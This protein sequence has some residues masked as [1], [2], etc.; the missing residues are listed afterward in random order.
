MDISGERAF[1]LLQKIGYIRTSGT[2]E[3]MKTAEILKAEAESCGVAAVIEP[4]DVEDAEITAASLTVLAPYEKTYEVTAYKCA[5]NTP[6][7]GLVADFYY[8]ENLSDAD[9]AA[10]KGKIVLVNGYLRLIPYQKMRE[11]G[12]VG[13]ITMS[14][15]LLD[16][17]GDADLFTRGLRDKL[18]TFGSMPGVNIAIA[19]AF[20]I[21]SKKAE[22]VRLTLQNTPVTRTS[23]NVIATISGTKY[24]DEII[25][26][27]AHFDSVPFSTGVYDNGAGSVINM[28]MLRH[29]AQN[30][31]LR[32]VQ[33][34]WYGSEEIGLCGSFAY[35]KAHA[36]DVKHTR[37][38]V[39][40][41]VAGPVLGYDVARVTGETALVNF[42]DYFMKTKGYGVTVT[43]DIYSSDSIPFA[44][45]GVPAVNFGRDGAEGAAF[46]HCRHDVLQYLSADALQKTMT[47]LLD[48]TS[49]LINAAAFP[50]ARKMPEEMTA[51]VDKYLYKKEI[52]AYLENADK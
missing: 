29:F 22:K 51:S 9:L 46:I 50:I 1:A 14:G 47:H 17:E 18:R 30:P 21:V 33:F 7:D 38:M 6:A 11:A 32:T 16:K 45:T 28:E 34:C 31:P 39:N 13:F 25:S 23:H 4:F 27:G 43:Q 2:A 35:V 5:E 36:D 10:A 42:T 26:F 24:P 40:V 48:Y 12:V 41:D 37:L 19:D 3:E 49:T 8:A 20:E 44:E 52:A 15:S